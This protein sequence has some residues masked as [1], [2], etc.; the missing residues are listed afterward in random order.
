MTIGKTVGPHPRPIGRLPGFLFPNDNYLLRIRE[1]S[2]RTLIHDFEVIWCKP[3]LWC[4]WKEFMLLQVCFRP[5]FVAE[6]LDSLVKIDRELSLVLGCVLVKRQK[7]FLCIVHLSDAGLLGVIFRRE[8]C[9]VLLR[10]CGRWPWCSSC[11]SQ[12]PPENTD[13]TAKFQ[14]FDGFV[15]QPFVLAAKCGDS[16]CGSVTFAFQLLDLLGKWRVLSLQ[17]L[18]VRAQ[19]V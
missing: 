7:P 19:L 2:D 1:F 17:R 10:W 16:L 9:S 12:L 8:C 15:T 11:L 14:Q 3:I 6:Q 18:N 13:R 5:G 4:V